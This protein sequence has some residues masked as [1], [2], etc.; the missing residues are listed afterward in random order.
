MA[1]APDQFDP[2]DET[3]LLINGYF[4]ISAAGDAPKTGR[5]AT[6]DIARDEN[7]VIVSKKEFE[8]FEALR[9]EILAVL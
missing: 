4:Q 7:S 9:E 1:S 5:K 3:G 8:A 2:A 6:S